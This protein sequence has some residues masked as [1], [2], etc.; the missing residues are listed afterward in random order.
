MPTPG[1]LEGRATPSATAAFARDSGLPAGN[2]REAMGVTVS[3]VGI[4]TYLGR[5]DDR[6]DAAYEEALRRALQL[7]INV[8]DSAINYR[9]QRSE[10]AVGRA[11][12]ARVVPRERIVV[13]TKG[14][15]LPFDAVRPRDPRSFVEET[16]VRPGL[17]RWDEVVDG[18]HCMAPRFLADQI[19][20]SRRNLGV[21]TIDLYY[22]H[23]PETQLGEV[24]RGEF[25]RRLRDAFGELERACDEQRIAAYGTATWN[26][27]R[28]AEDDSEY[29][30][31]DEVVECAREVA[32]AR[33]RFRAVQ[34]P[35]NLEMDEAA[36]LENQRG[37][38]LLQAARDSGI[39]VFASAPVL[40]GRLAHLS[41]A[42]RERLSRLETD[43]QR[44]L[45][46]VRATAG[47]TCALVGMKTVSHVEEN[48]A[49][50]RTA[51][52]A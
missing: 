9:N 13:C 37:R 46:F 32:G 19:D 30:S 12:R 25:F 7:G 26:G 1:P 40:Q 24:P 15:F 2:F 10:R 31:L 18:V 8:V 38:T 35:F 34:L 42:E 44:A 49:V 50:T 3:S 22:L 27:Y 11:L 41:P 4:G 5:D 14:G 21:A 33:H 6:T 23:N 29:L 47:I 36:A 16:Y 52:A 43:A 20:R 48:A 28:V 51:P 17:L 45:Q 39:A